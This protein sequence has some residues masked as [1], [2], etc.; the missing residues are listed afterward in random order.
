MK[1]EWNKI[2]TNFWLSHNIPPYIESQIMYLPLHYIFLHSL[3]ALLSLFSVLLKLQVVLE[4]SSRIDNKCWL[5]PQQL[6][7]TLWCWARRDA[8]LGVETSGE[9]SDHAAESSISLTRRRRPSRLLVSATEDCLGNSKG[10][11]WVQYKRSY[12]NVGK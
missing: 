3:I 12:E 10:K 4:W 8:G 2:S 6:T 9:H 11:V 7:A 1:N 5:P